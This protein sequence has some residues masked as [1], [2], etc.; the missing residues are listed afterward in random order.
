MKAKYHLTPKRQVIVA[1]GLDIT[2]VLVWYGN[3]NSRPE[4]QI[5]IFFS[6]HFTICICNLQTTLLLLEEKSLLRTLF[7][8]AG[9]A[10][11]RNKSGTFFFWNR[12]CCMRQNKQSYH[13]TLNSNQICFSVCIQKGG[14]VTWQDERRN[15]ICV[16]PLPQ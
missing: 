16:S 3:A 15:Q 6:F 4:K 12:F 7:F 2:T 11:L 1:L 8:W 13:N 5:F 10:I 9:M 14:K